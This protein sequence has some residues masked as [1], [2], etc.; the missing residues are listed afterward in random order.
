MKL[1]KPKAVIFDWD[2]TLIDAWSILHEAMK[3]TFE[4]F[5]KKPFTIEETK[6]YVHKS[7]KD[8]FPEI[9]GDKWQDAAKRF[10]VYY[11]N[12]HLTHL[13]PFENTIDTLIKLSDNNIKMSIL[14]NKKGDILRQEVEHFGWTKYFLKIV[15]SLDTPEDKPSAIPALAIIKDMQ[16]D[17]PKEVW[18]IGDS[19]ADMECA[20]NSGCIPIFFGQN[21]SLYNG[22]YNYS[23]G[24]H[25][26]LLK[27]FEVSSKT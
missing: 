17:S 7:L 10:Y 27:L 16:L 1:T 8:S 20:N 21:N 2:N 15:G 23:V 24:S 12:N 19:V 9:F 26:E 18:F 14:S 22:L 5:G 6:I 4:E 13:K 25:K 11:L 3:S